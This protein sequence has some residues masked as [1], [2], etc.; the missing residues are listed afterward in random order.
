M[1]VLVVETLASTE[2]TLEDLYS[3]EVASAE[4]TGRNFNDY[5]SPLLN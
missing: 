3:S 5:F 2:G 4:S 1:G